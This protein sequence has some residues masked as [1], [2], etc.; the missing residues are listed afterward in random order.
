L[1]VSEVVV[2]HGI[3]QQVKGRHVLRAEL[4]AALRDGVAAAAGAD[5]AAGQ[6]EFAFYGGVFRPKGEV[7]G[8]Q[9]F[10]DA[11]D[12]ADGLE[13]E[14][15]RAWWERAAAV[16]E[17]VVP[18]DAEVLSRSPRRAQRALFALSNS[19]Y[20]AA[21]GDSVLS[22]LVG[23]LEQVSGYLADDRVRQDGQDAVASAVAADTRVMVGHSLGSVVAYEAL[24]AH[25]K[26]PVRA[27]VTL[28]S[29]LGLRLVFDRLRPPPAPGPDPGVPR[30]AWPGPVTAWWPSPAPATRRHGSGTSWPRAT[31][32]CALT[33]RC[34]SMSVRAALDRARSNC[35]LFASAGARSKPRRLAKSSRPRRPQDVGT[36]KSQ[37]GDLC[38]QFDEILAVGN[39]RLK[40]DA[41][42]P[43]CDHAAS[44]A[45]GP[46]R[47]PRSATARATA[48]TVGVCDRCRWCG[49]C[50][51]VGPG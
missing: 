23:D 14:L 34:P 6:V 19:R 7:L 10:F 33:T 16:D 26:W 44:P 4:F 3:G 25:P 5:I 46:T 28:G 8:A 51:G 11:G 30:G 41:A 39:E 13:Q 21:A 43:C 29:P 20:F 9:E 35:A 42:P 12:V 15:L 38:I 31:R 36:I 37:R 47:L 1:S 45:V 18:P 2:V 50:R 49:Q 48:A 22:L 27:L 17:R 40:V 24:C 32:P